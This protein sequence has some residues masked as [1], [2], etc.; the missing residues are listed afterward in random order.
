M[1]P[2]VTKLCH[3]S[4]KNPNG[5]PAYNNNFLGFY[6]ISKDFKKFYNIANQKILKNLKIK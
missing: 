5:G 4:W 1:P 6:K 3:P 2:P